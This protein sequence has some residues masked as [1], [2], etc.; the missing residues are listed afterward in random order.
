MAKYD[1]S[2]GSLKDQINGAKNILV[3]LPS[4]VSPDKLAA[5]LSLYLSLKNAGKEVG[6]ASSDT[7]LVSH[8][9]LYGVGSVSSVLPK[10][11][12]GNLVLTLEGVV[13]NDGQVPGLE[14]L[15]WYPKG[16]DLNLVFHTIP[17]Q[18]FEPKKVT[19][20]YQGGSIDLVLVMGAPSLDALG[21]LYQNNQ[22][23]FSGTIVNIDNE[24]SN[25]NFG[26]INIVDPTAS[27]SEIV[28]QILP[29]LG[30]NIDSDIASNILVGIYD[31]TTNLTNKTNPDTFLAVGFC[32]Q[33]GGKNPLTQTEQVAIHGT[34]P[35]QP[36]N[37][38]PSDVA[39]PSEFPPLN[40]VFG[41]PAPSRTPISNEFIVPL[42]INQNE[43]TSIPSA[44][45]RPQGEQA[46][47]SNTEST[48]DP[49]WLSPK[50]F[51]ANK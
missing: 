45:E 30:L 1:S 22:N 33:A 21:S 9:N 13:A 41:F 39:R 16:S 5:G 3:A 47:E 40:Q 50:V 18:K 25:S 14:K 34:S 10:T 44:E 7:L 11:Q 28:A 12:G 27:L 2:L 17:N 49:S 51:Q 15:D 31:A 43:P 42:V 8:S 48:P 19:P 24:G 37:V 29:S 38:P 32:M 20:S 26:V 35:E 46:L 6:I 4:Q 36:V 23:S